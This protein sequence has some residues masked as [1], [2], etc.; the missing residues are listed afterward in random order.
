M[1]F[2]ESDGPR[3]H[4]LQLLV[5]PISWIKY[6][7]SGCFRTWRPSPFFGWPF[8]SGSSTNYS[9]VLMGKFLLNLFRKVINRVVYTWRGAGREGGREG[10]RN[11]AGTFCDSPEIVLPPVR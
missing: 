8:I 4:L 10:G 6:Y 5:P 9:T 1:D 11:Y 7:L 3:D 2:G